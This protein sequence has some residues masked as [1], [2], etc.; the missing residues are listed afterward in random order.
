MG[1][2]FYTVFRCSRKGRCIEICAVLQENRLKCCFLEL[3]K[4]TPA[5]V[6]KR[7]KA[8]EASLVSDFH[9]ASLEMPWLRLYRI[10]NESTE[11]ENCYLSLNRELRGLWNSV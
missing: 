8:N 9:R 3:L 10:T 1:D 4:T 7:F 6:M 11:I 5:S 2:S